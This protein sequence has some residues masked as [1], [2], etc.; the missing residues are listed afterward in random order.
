MHTA[1]SMCAQKPSICTQRSDANRHQ[2]QKQTV[3]S[4]DFELSETKE[5]W[6]SLRY[7]S[8]WTDHDSNE[9]S[10]GNEQSKEQSKSNKQYEISCILT[11]RLIW[12][13]TFRTQSTAQ[14][15]ARMTWTADAF[16][17]AGCD[18]IWPVVVASTLWSLNAVS[19]Q[20]CFLLRL[21][22]ESCIKRCNLRERRSVEIQT[23]CQ[24][25]HDHA[26]CTYLHSCF[27]YTVL[28]KCSICSYPHW[29]R[30][31]REWLKKQDPR[32]MT[33]SHPKYTYIDKFYFYISIAFNF[34]TYILFILIY[35]YSYRLRH[36]PYIFIF[37]YFST[38]IL[39]YLLT[40]VPTY[41]LTFT[42]S[43]ICTSTLH[44]YK[45]THT[46]IFR[47]LHLFACL[48]AC[49][50][51]YLLTYFLACLFA[52]MSACLLACLHACM[53]TYLLPF[54]HTYILTSLHTYIPS[55]KRTYI[56]TCM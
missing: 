13:T 23:C 2:K 47:Y 32:H 10:K 34:Y 15:R 48:L 7:L 50:P 38:Y 36:I 55:Y 11:D 17:G 52:C 20:T 28:I 26:R 42:H 44:T 41:I 16:S 35:S 46:Y 3:V 8:R 43:Y 24:Q 18:G 37:I 39:T 19:W 33:Q 31:L 5:R 30:T 40:Y 56:L 45:L 6:Q 1:A 21:T 9:R 29:L 14:W 51:T 54:S 49:L 53:L 27:Q 22:C 12:R 25:W 4:A